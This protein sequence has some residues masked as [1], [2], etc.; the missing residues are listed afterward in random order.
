MDKGKVEFGLC[1]II[2][3]YG[4]LSILSFVGSEPRKAN[5]RLEPKLRKEEGER[6]QARAKWPRLPLLVNL[7]SVQVVQQAHVKSELALG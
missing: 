5:L 2:C 4:G 1:C 3:N 7:I 6:A